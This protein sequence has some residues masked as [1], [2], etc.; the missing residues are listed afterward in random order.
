MAPQPR[1]ERSALR[2]ATGSTARRAA[3][4]VLIRGARLL[5]PRAGL[6]GAGR[7]AGP[8]RRDRR[9][10]ATGARARPTGAEVVDGEGLH[11]L[12]GLRRPARAPAHA[13]A[14]G[15]GGHRLR[16]ARRRGRRLLRDP[17]DAQHRPGGR[18]GA[19][20]ALA[21]RARARARR[22]SRS[23]SSP[24]SR[25]GQQGERAHRDGRAAPRR[26]RSASPTTACPSLRGRD[27]PG[28]PVPAPRRRRARAAR[29]GPVAVA[30]TARCTRAR[31]R[32][33]SG[34]PASRRSPSRRWS[35]A[36]A[37]SP[38]Y[39]DGRIHIQHLSARESVEAIERAKAAGVA[40]HLRGHA[41]PPA[42]DRRGGARRSTR[43]SR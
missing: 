38:R 17:R 39:E 14:R 24:R 6:D 32:R 8:R 33:C 28:A 30:A 15:R 16:H 37:R 23:A 42:A 40:G 31:S 19:G 1:D 12:P 25:V 29:G 10:R 11:A 43:N 7:R 26:A 18:L 13:R 36:T 9:D 27:A 5:D 3:H 2:A 4:D 35:R 21:A 34:S 41:A 22:A 20:P